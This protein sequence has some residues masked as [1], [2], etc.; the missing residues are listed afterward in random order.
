MFKLSAKTWLIGKEDNILQK[1]NDGQ[2]WSKIVDELLLDAALLGHIFERS[3]VEDAI[4]DM[5]L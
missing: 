4:S 5:E 1:L 2:S 3:E